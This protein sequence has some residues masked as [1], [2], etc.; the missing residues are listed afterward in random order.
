MESFKFKSRGEGIDF[1]D[2]C[3]CCEKKLGT[4]VDNISAFVESEE[5]GEL[6]VEVFFNGY[7]RLDYRESE[8]NWIQVKFGTCAHCKPAMSELMRLTR[9]GTIYERDVILSKL[10][11]KYRL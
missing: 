7:A 8:P 10:M 9:D 6:I 4:P 5:E 1:I 2:N 3:F 11:G